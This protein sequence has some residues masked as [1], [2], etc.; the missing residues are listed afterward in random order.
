[1]DQL[2]SLASS[3]IEKLEL[4]GMIN[5]LIRKRN[6]VIKKFESKNMINQRIRFGG[7][8]ISGE[9]MEIFHWIPQNSSTA[10]T[11]PKVKVI[12]FGED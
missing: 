6:K 10:S 3:D 12:K 11:L 1:M 8:F 7:F 5:I 2:I 4:E 9:N